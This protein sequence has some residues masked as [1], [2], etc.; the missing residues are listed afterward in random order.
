[1]T[2]GAFSVFGGATGWDWFM[3]LRKAEGMVSLLGR[4]GARICYVL[5]GVAII[6]FGSFF[7]VAWLIWDSR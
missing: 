1:V 3:N 7:I 6:A 4:T 5:S 2:V